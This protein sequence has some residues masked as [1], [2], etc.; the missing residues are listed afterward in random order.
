MR[1][2]VH[3]VSKS[4]GATRVLNKVNLE[5]AAGEIHAL[6]GENG[7]GK[8][9]LMK[10]LSGIYKPDHGK[11]S[12]DGAPFSPGTPYFARKAGVSMIY[13][14]P[15]LALDLTA[16]ENIVLGSEASRRGWLDKRRNRATA[17]EALRK[18]HSEE[19]PLDL[20]VGL[21][22]VAQ[23]R[24]VEI[25][26]AL[27][28]EPKVLILDEPT[29]ALPQGDA[30]HLFEAIRQLA[31]H[32][33]SIIYISHF[34]E[35]CLELCS[36]YTVLRDGEAVACGYMDEVDR[37]TLTHEMLGK[38]LSVIYPRRDHHIGNPILEVKDLV[39]RSTRYP[40]G[41]NFTLRAGEIFGIAGLTGS[42]RT[43][44]LRA[45][46]GLEAT[47]RGEVFLDG[48][49]ITD[50]S[51]ANRLRHRIGYVS[52]NRQQEGV[53]LTRSVAENMTLTYLQ[54]C[55]RLGIISTERQR[56][57]ALD[58][59]E[60]LRVRGRGPSQPI[61]E[62]SGGNQQKVAIGRLLHH[63]ARIFLLDEPTRGVDIGS[64]AQI[65]ELIGEMAAEGR[66]ILFVSSYLPEL[67]GICD[68]IGVMN[69]G[70]LTAV[71]P[72]SEWTE[73]ELFSAAMGV[74]NYEAATHC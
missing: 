19:I 46:F 41:V 28:S 8:S 23:Q 22:P 54:D 61:V 26:R 29:S 70:R 24:R 14:E 39:V 45:L 66:A 67:L 1:L 57:A 11:I 68:T 56:M 5:V 3:G 74:A 42:G 48:K 62:L 53:M 7:A 6:I 32:G 49:R 60:K 63:R 37:P 69:R 20:P 36:R 31:S 50:M 16:Q 58:W 71:R 55:S 21:L 12:L 51:P 40:Q 17:K 13:Q 43:A 9:T 25:A 44:L 4:L 72:A 27:T 47:K 10:I 33:V 34:L 30:Q 64:K 15:A 65:Y 59:M 18:I 52:E 38:K 35:N 2:Q 73:H